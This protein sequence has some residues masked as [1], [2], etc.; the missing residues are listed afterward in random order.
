MTNFSDKVL[1]FYSN[2]KINV[3][4]PDDVSVM[5]PYGN[6]DVIKVVVAFYEK[7]YADAKRRTM[8]LGINPGRFG[9]G[10]TGIPFTDPVQL[11]Q[12]CKI[13][14][15]FDKK[16]ELS[17]IFIYQ[18]IEAFGSI[19]KFYKQFYISSISPL[20]F[21][22]DGKNMNYYDAKTLQNILQDFILESIQKQID[23]GT[24]QDVCYCLGQ[25]KNYKYLNDLNKEHHFFEKII[26]L[27]HPRYILQYKRKF[28]DRYINEYLTKFEKMSN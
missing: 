14:N 18:M 11:E 22:K 3:E 17:S 24:K 23:F 6:E 9:A 1:N 10:I 27:A 15:N 28:V 2:L 8:I 12:K 19:K 25:G 26:P 20:G 7:Y 4:L 13:R 16:P 21:V 5:D